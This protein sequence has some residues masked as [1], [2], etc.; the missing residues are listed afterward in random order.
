LTVDVPIA[1]NTNAF[2]GAGYQFVEDKGKPTPSG[3]QSGLAIVAGV[4]SEVAKNFL[5]YGN[6]TV[7]VNAY[8]NSS[9]S[10][11]SVGTG[12]GYRFK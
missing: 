7:G 1:R 6:A 10:A 5:L 11:V 3:N 4:E 8:R 2:V 12:I 9:A